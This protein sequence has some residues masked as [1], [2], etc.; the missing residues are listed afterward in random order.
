MMFSAFVGKKAGTGSAH[1]LGVGRSA[2]LLEGGALHTLF[3]I[4]HS[5]FLYSPQFIYLSNLL[6]T[7]V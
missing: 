2:P 1:V 7:S 5:R 4:L 3:G 6:V